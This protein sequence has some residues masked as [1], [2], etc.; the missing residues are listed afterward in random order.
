MWTTADYRRIYIKSRLAWFEVGRPPGAESA[1]INPPGIAMP[2]AGLC[3]TD[4]T[5]FFKCRLD[6]RQ[7]VD[8][9]QRGL[10]R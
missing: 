7:R 3:F 2:P 1:F 5:F 9:S 8:G 6:I 4:V 10:L